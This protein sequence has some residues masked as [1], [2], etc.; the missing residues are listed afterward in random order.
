MEPNYALLTLDTLDFPV[1]I[2]DSRCSNFLFLNRT[3]R[4]E[5]TDNLEKISTHIVNCTAFTEKA[6]STTSASTIFQ[7]QLRN[8]KG[9]ITNWEVT[10]HL[11]S[12]GIVSCVFKRVEKDAEILGY[13]KSFDELAYVTA[14]WFE[15]D[16]ELNDLRMLHVSKKTIQRWKGKNYEEIV[17]RFAAR[18]LGMPLKEIEEMIPTMIQ[19]ENENIAEICREF[20]FPTKSIGIF[21]YVFLGYNNGDKNKP[22]FLLAF[23]VS[24]DIRKMENTI[25]EKEKLI[26]ELEVE[27]IF[28]FAP[29]PMGVVDVTDE[30]N[31]RFRYVIVNNS[32]AS[33]LNKT[34]DEL[35]GKTGE[36]IGTS[37][38]KEIEF[39]KILLTNEAEKAP[40]EFEMKSRYGTY[41]CVTSNVGN[42]RFLLSCVNI[43]EL[44]NLTEELK[45][46]KD[47]LEKL[48]EDRT[49]ELQEALQVKG[50]FLAIMSHEMRT[51]LTGLIGALHLLSETKLNEEQRELTNI[52]EV[53]GSQLLVV[54]NDILDLSKM[55]EKKMTLEKVPVELAKILEDSLDVVALEAEK[56]G[57]ELILRWIPEFPSHLIGDMVRIRQ[58]LVN[59]LTN[60][61][62]F[63]EHGEIVVSSTSRKLEDDIYEFQFSVKDTGIELTRMQNNTYFNL[64]PKQILLLPENTTEV[65]WG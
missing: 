29:I 20:S 63:T 37:R 4:E 59:L 3:L 12:Y 50:R 23:S 34:P 36:E 33:I 31:F 13:W 22:R 9:G 64:S 24:N 35:K 44:K 19:A 32:Y 65:D 39:V 16:K 27:K 7:T 11:I 28:K 1:A 41:S 56:K 18:D 21:K 62:K 15:Y 52:A 48:V 58:I 6:L 55:E 10:F 53:S 43:T 45:V 60:A 14:S 42:N 5:T 2:F 8:T 38:H 25:S 26:N 51:P 40:I 57:L 47:H 30:E 61:V 49:F 17:G 54:I 46:H